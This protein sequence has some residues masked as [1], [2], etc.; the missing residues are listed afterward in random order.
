MEPIGGEPLPWPDQPGGAEGGSAGDLDARLEESLG[1]FDETVLGGGV[2]P[3]DQGIDILDP[4]GGG[5]GGASSDQPI[6]EEGDL[7]EGEGAEGELADGQGTMENS[8]IAQRAEAGSGMQGG[9]TA[10]GGSASA[11]GASGGAAGGAAGGGAAAAGGVGSGSQ[12]TA[13]GDAEV[14]ELPPDVGDGRNDDIVLRQI[15]DAATHERDPVLREK[16]WDEYRR[17]QAQR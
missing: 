9:G 14:I 3:A 12:G 13:Q 5:A 8:D 4:M 1:D 7:D 10:G 17:I 11:G 6:F 2:A 15:R 16:L